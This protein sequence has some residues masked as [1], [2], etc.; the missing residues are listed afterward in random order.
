MT[1]P[2]PMVSLGEVLSHRKQFIEIDDTQTYKRCRV[3]LHAQ[4]VVLRKRLTER[5]QISIAM[6]RAF[7]LS[8]FSVFV[9]TPH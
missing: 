6:L 9:A 1:K 3:Q 7:P 8:L 2:W 4:G 5:I